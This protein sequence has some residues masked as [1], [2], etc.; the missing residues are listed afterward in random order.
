MTM[1]T[2]NPELV[3]ALK[4]LELGRIAETL[5]E[6]LVLAHTPGKRA[7]S[8]NKWTRGNAIR[9]ADPATILGPDPNATSKAAPRPHWA[10]T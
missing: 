3:G 7:C 4:R 1:A 8:A 6:R 9:L 5:P 10:R 2:L